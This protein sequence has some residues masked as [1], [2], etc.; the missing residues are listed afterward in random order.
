MSAASDPFICFAADNDGRFAV[1]GFM[2]AFDATATFVSLLDL[3]AGQD[4]RL[5]EVVD[6]LPEV[7][8]V[9]REVVTPWEQK[10]A[11]MRVLVEQAKSR[12]VDLVDGVR[13]HH[14]EGWALVL[15]DP[16]DPITRVTAEGVDQQAAERLAD[17]YVRRIE[18]LVRS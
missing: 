18:Q 6:G 9:T 1:P 7:F 11:V 8:M 5:S 10:G 14:P 13:I 16:D 3:L 12:E 2:P 4:R 17:E 15:P